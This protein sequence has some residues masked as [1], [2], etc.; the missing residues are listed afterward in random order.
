MV[1]YVVF[2]CTAFVWLCT[3]S[4]AVAQSYPSKPVRWIVPN[5]PGGP[6]DIVARVIANK[7]GPLLGH[8]VIVDN[9]P[10]ADQIIGT[11]A[12]A[13]AAPDGYTLGLI[14]PAHTTNPALR[15]LP[16]DSVKDVAPIGRLVRF[17]LVLVVSGSSPANSVADVIGLA[18]KR[19]SDFRFASS[20]S[21][22]GPH[23]A[24]ELL[25][26]ASGT[27]MTHVPFKGTPEVTLSVLRGEIDMYFDSPAV[28][29]GLGASGRLKPIAVSSSQ[30]S[31]IA[32]SLPTIAETLSGFDVESFI[33]LA[34]PGKTPA[35]AIETMSRS[36][37]SVLD[38]PDVRERFAA[39][40]F[41]PSFSTPSEFA[42]QLA[43]ETAKWSKVIKATGIHI[44]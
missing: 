1:R 39:I 34:A 15:K 37:R 6:I 3:T 30:R 19:G 25:K 5:P 41:E 33:G 16:Y 22:T 18:K 28:L 14:G 13:K 7:M 36:I 21:G 35:E 2:A 4:L 44:E 32:P 31:S 11:D 40:A 12:L 23:L 24:G 20:G 29:T 42:A 8:E 26:S 27:D 10:G 17:P 38:M 43:R 9:R